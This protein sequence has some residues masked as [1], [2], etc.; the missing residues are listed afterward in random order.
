MADYLTNLET[1]RNQLVDRILEVTLTKKPSY[2]IDGQSV[3]W[4]SYLNTLQTQLM[5][6]NLMINQADPFELE[7]D[8]CSE[9]W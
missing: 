4:E 7:S 8:A 1:I 5:N 6:V 9:G 3:S 2:S